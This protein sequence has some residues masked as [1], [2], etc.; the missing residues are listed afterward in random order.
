M[1]TLNWMSLEE[2]LSQM[3]KPWILGLLWRTLTRNRNDR[4]INDRKKIQHIEVRWEIL[5]HTFRYDLFWADMSKCND[6]TYIYFQTTITTVRSWWD[7]HHIRRPASRIFSIAQKGR[8]IW[9]Q[10]ISTL[11]DTNLPSSINVSEKSVENFLIN[12]VSIT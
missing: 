10:K 1:R 2:I 3:S 5:K 4:N 9:T 11:D 7:L 6:D 8:Q 12:D